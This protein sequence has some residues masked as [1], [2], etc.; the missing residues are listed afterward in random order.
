MFQQTAPAPEFQRLRRIE[1]LFDPATRARLRATG[2]LEGRRV[3]EVGAGAGSVAHWLADQVGSGGRVVAVDID[4]RFLNDLKG[5]EVVQGALGHVEFEGEFDLIHARYVAIHNENVDDL[6]ESMVALLA[7]G[8]W[9][10]LEE[11]DFEV[12]R[13]LAGAPA[14]RE[15]FDRVNRA[16]AVMFESRGMVAGLGAEL[17]ARLHAHLRFEQVDVT[18]HVAAGASPVARMMQ[19]STEQ[20]RDKY[21]ATGVASESDI[22]GYI[23]FTQDPDCW[24]VYY[25]TGS[26]SGRR[27]SEPDSVTI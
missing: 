9:L 2:S 19:Q 14:L 23:A 21:V 8:G 13:A 3:L 10:V 18:P 16:I 12:A 22:A 7:P 25:A 24:G 20:L 1:A 15:A 4:T 11:P 17:A 27:R 26:V 6:L 5:V